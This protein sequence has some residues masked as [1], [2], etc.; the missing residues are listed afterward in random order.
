V[1]RHDSLARTSSSEYYQVPTRREHD[2]L[3]L[4]ASGDRQSAVH[5]DSLAAVVDAMTN[6]TRVVCLRVLS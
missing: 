3:P 2:D 4:F 1:K 5:A 6:L